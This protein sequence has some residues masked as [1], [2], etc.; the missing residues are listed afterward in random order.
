MRE[1]MRNI[2]QIQKENDTLIMKIFD[3]DYEKYSPQKCQ[4]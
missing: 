4:V 3:L 1:T 2:E